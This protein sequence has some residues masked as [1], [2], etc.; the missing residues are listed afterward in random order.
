MIVTQVKRK[1][2]YF[3]THK[4]YYKFYKLSPQFILPAN[5]LFKINFLASQLE[6]Q[7]VLIIVLPTFASHE[8]QFS[9]IQNKFQNNPRAQHSLW[10]WLSAVSVNIFQHHPNDCEL[11]W[12]ATFRASSGML[13]LSCSI[14]LVSTMIS[15]SSVAKS[16]T[17][18]TSLPKHW[19]QEEMKKLFVVKNLRYFKVE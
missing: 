3:K 4:R 13:K 11:T 2:W 12:R 15:D 7:H 16:T 10:L 6:K 19:Q 5:T 8:P 17:Y 14:Y 9:E 18:F 1:M